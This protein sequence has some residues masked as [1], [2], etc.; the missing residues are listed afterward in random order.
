MRVSKSFLLT[1]SGFIYLLP[2]LANGKQ[3][4]T[5]FVIDQLPIETPHDASIYMTCN[6]FEWLPNLEELSFNRTKNGLWILTLEHSYDTL[7]YK[8]TRGNWKSVEARQNGR[9]LPNRVWIASKDTNTVHL[10][11]QSWEDISYPA[12]TVYMVFLIL[13]CLLGMFLIIAIHTIKNQHKKANHVLSILL[14]LL[15]LSLLGRASTFDPTIFNWQPKLILIPEIILFT[16][17][18]IFY[19]YIKTLLNLK[20]K[21]SKAWFHFVPAMAH[22]IFYLPI[23]SMEKQAFI[24]QILDQKLFVYFGITGLIALAF[25]IVYWM[26]CESMIRNDK[27]TK[28][29][30]EQ[31]HRYITFLKRVM[32]IK[33]VYLFLWLIAMLVYIAGEALAIDLLY[34]TEKLIDTLWLL[35]SLIIFA[36]AYFAIANPEFLH[37]KKRY[38]HNAMNKKEISELMSRLKI[39]LEEEQVF[40]QPGLTLDRLAYMIPTTPHTLSRLINEQYCKSF[41]EFINTYR[42]EAFISKMSKSASITFLELALSVGFNS[43]P[44]FNR[45]FK[46]EKGCTP[47]DYFLTQLVNH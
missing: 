31:Q 33:A 19:L 11:V 5:Q 8:I 14:I 4:T 43:K 20:L 24:Y 10:N 18:P 22:L 15:I 41:T 38:Q 37:E 3:H 26:L 40:T 47:K 9:A 1:I 42:V 46:K 17:A 2:Y 13:S 21:T 7:Y 12:Y 45:A 39:L 25:N 28:Q 16:Y 36:L 44:T 29:L 35:L 6:A 34:L 27:S 23:L 30:N 32:K